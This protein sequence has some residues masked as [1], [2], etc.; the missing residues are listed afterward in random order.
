MALLLGRHYELPQC[1]I[2]KEKVLSIIIMGVMWE[3]GIF[4]LEMRYVMSEEEGLGM[5]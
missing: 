4:V 5:Q 3:N 1:G 2:I